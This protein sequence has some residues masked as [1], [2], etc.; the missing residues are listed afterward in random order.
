M[1]N[2]LLLEQNALDHVCYKL[3]SGVRVTATHRKI[4]LSGELNVSRVQVKSLNTKKISTFSNLIYRAYF[5]YYFDFPS[6]IQL[7]F[8]DWG[9]PKNGLC[10]VWASQDSRRSNP[11]GEWRAPTKN[12]WVER[13][14][15][16][17]LVD[18]CHAEDFNGGQCNI[19]H[20]KKH[21]GI[22]FCR[23]TDDCD[24]PSESDL[25]FVK[26]QSKQMLFISSTYQT[27]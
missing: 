23:S 8:C 20:A 9:L 25:M 22:G 18:H 5:I 11:F 7:D 13:P 16:S 21:G 4:S 14:S 17:D 26:P 19:A 1:K 6:F 24:G 2:A 27:L 10:W 15:W 12:E 3:E